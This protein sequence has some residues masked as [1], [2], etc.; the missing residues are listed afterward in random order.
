MWHCVNFTVF[1]F[2]DYNV[3]RIFDAYD[4]FLDDFTSIIDPVIDAYNNAV[5]VLSNWTERVG[6]SEIVQTFRGIEETIKN[7]TESKIL[8]L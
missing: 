1:F 6:E 4:K 7:F 2:Q 8:N 3:G 5:N